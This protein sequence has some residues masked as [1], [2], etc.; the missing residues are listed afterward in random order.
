MNGKHKRINMDLK[1][2]R[3]NG[4]DNDL[5]YGSDG[6]SCFDLVSNKDVEWSAHFIRG[7]I[8][9]Y[10]A[11]IP[12]GFKFEIPEGWRMDIYPRSGWGFKYNIQ[13]ANGTGKIDSDY[14]GEVQVKLI[15]FSGL[16]NLPE[17]KKGERIAQ[18]ELNLV[19]KANFEYVQILSETI[20][21]EDGFG[22]TGTKSE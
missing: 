2:K 7:H 1:I 15:A 12:T 17:I 9:C 4:Q 8:V 18:A 10:E 14:R 6:A 11:I 19:H 21:G 20:R 22:S 5:V 16:E 13:L 3:I